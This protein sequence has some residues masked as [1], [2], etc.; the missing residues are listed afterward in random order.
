ML[1]DVRSGSKA[2]LSAAARH[3][4]SALIRRRAALD[5]GGPLGARTGTLALFTVWRATA[6]EY[7]F[8]CRL[9]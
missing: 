2:V 7:A 6:A 3:V 1:A 8:S 4:R 5:I 9:V